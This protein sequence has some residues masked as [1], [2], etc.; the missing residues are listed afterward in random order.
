MTLAAVF[1]I[2]ASIGSSFVTWCVGQFSWPADN[3]RQ[4][5][6]LISTGAM[7]SVLQS[8]GEMGTVLRRN[9][10]HMEFRLHPQ[11]QPV[12]DLVGGNGE[13][14]G[15]PNREHQCHALLLSILLEW[16]SVSRRMNRR[17]NP[18]GH[19]IAQAQEPNLVLWDVISGERIFVY[20][21]HKVTKIWGNGVDW[22]RVEFS[23]NGARAVSS[24]LWD[25]N[26]LL[27]D[28]TTGKTIARF[29]GLFQFQ[30]F[31]DGSLLQTEGCG[32]GW[33]QP[34]RRTYRLVDEM[35]SMIGSWSMPCGAGFG[36]AHPVSNSMAFVDFRPSDDCKLLA[37]SN[38]H[39]DQE[40]RTA[41]PLCDRLLPS[42][43]RDLEKLPLSAQRAR[44]KTRSHHRVWHQCTTCA[45][46]IPIM[47][48]NRP[49][50]IDL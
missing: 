16:F 21:G 30:F 39:Q 10:H 19:R 24:T 23:P 40:V 13:P 2:A 7:R 3:A 44:T 11:A 17:L 38:D 35:G 42:Q 37:A 18:D 27:W 20:G 49:Y 14:D 9:L 43:G 12:N 46:R 8:A 47:S 50:F 31:P 1:S 36:R 6:S 33:S 25:E 34:S 4:D 48:T 28:V 15:P 26:T 22:G 29:N 45:W 41:P 5:Q 32:P